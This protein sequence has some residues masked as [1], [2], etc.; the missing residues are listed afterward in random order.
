MNE[1]EVKFNLFPQ[2]EIFIRKTFFAIGAS[3]K[4]VEFT[5]L[6]DD[7]NFTFL[8]SGRTLRIRA[9]CLPISGSTI[10]QIISA[11]VDLKSPSS[12]KD[13]NFRE[14]E[15]LPIAD[16]SEIAETSRRLRKNG[17]NCIYFYTKK[18]EEWESDGLKISIDNL[19]WLGP[20]LEIEGEEKKIKEMVKYLKIIGSK[21]VITDTT[22]QLYHKFFRISGKK[23]I[24]MIPQE[25]IFI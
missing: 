7:D 13:I 4:T 23:P 2:E 25:I 6:Y 17:L 14:E 21:S 24:E 16:F 22:Y 5:A 11:S 8:K 12:R 1:I 15:S 9:V 19:L 3:K 20:F 10:L 18:K